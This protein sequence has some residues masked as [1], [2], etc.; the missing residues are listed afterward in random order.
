MASNPTDGSNDSN[1]GYTI[2]SNA[3][4]ETE[5]GIVFP[6]SVKAFRFDTAWLNSISR[7]LRSGMEVIIDTD[8]APFTVVD[9]DWFPNTP[10]N[11]SV[12]EVSVPYS[13]RTHSKSVEAG[14]EQDCEFIAVLEKDGLSETLFT[15][16]VAWN[17][18]A[19]PLLARYEGE[20]LPEDTDLETSGLYSP[21]DDRTI[22]RIERIPPNQIQSD[23]TASDLIDQEFA[24]QGS[25]QTA[26][27]PLS[28]FELSGADESSHGD[29]P[30]LPDRFDAIGRC[31]NCTS[32]VVRDIN[33]DRVVCVD[34]RR[35]CTS[36][37]WANYHTT[38]DF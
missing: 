19:K 31:P 2:D 24:V 30:S 5:H 22:S 34:C 14:P 20:S 33:K 3:D 7:S 36:R 13:T 1:H 27:T 29:I 37:E 16:R 6:E 18:A 4:V 21:S 10:F 25:A 38:P 35:W 9:T 12:D 26:T 32:A 17:T 8:R 28:E 11:G 23:K 15:L